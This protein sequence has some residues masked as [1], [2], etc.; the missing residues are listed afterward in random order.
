MQW[1]KIQLF[2]LWRLT[3]SSGAKDKNLNSRNFYLSQFEI[4]A[5]CTQGWQQLH[6]TIVPVF[7]FRFILEIQWPWA[8]PISW[9]SKRFFEQISQRISFVPHQETW[10]K[11]RVK[12]I[13]QRIC[14]IFVF[15]SVDVGPEKGSSSFLAFPT[16]KKN[17]GQPEPLF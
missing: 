10:L 1:C 6:I 3:R 2:Y 16:R 13:N 15:C 7:Q 14:S 8:N 11:K 4:E 5:A 17:N 9:R 12:T